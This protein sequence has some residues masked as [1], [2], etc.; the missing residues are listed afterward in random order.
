[1]LSELKRRLLRWGGDQSMPPAPMASLPPNELELAARRYDDGRALFDLLRRKW[2][3]VPGGLM[4]RVETDALLGLSARELRDYWTGVW[5]EA[6]LGP[7]HAVR[8]WY[9]GL[10]ADIFRGKRVLEIG[11]GMGIDGLHFIKAGARWHF[12]D[13]VQSNLDL[14]AR[15]LDAFG[16]T[17][18]GFTWLRDLASIDALP[19][20]FDFIYAQGSL[21]NLPFALAR[22]ETL[23]LVRHLRPGGR[24]IELCYPKERWEREGALPFAAWGAKTDGERTPW[25]EWYDLARLR[26]RFDPVGVRDL[27]A[28]NFHHDDFNW[29]DLVIDD[30]PSAGAVSAALAQPAGQAVPHWPEIGQYAGSVSLSG[31]IWRHRELLAGDAD[32]AR[33]LAAVPRP[34]FVRVVDPLDLDTEMG[35]QADGWLD[36][37]DRAR[38]YTERSMEADDAVILAHVYRA[39]APRRHLE[40]GTWEGFGASLCARNCAAEIWTINL[41]AGEP[42]ADGGPAYSTVRDAGEVARIG[43]ITPLELDEQGRPIYQTDAGEFIGWRYRAEG[44]GARVHQILADST[45][46]DSSAFTDGFF[47]TILIDGGHQ[48]EVVHADTEQALRLLRP[49][50]LMIWHDFCPS[51]LVMNYAG[52][53]RGVVSALH[54]HWAEWSPRFDQLFWIRDSYILIGRLAS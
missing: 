39:A 14:I 35:W 33:A 6:S 8:G 17:C 3:E 21:I 40:F 36:G 29:F 42:R 34:V 37:F 19:D 23:R 15:E 44:F 26:Q 2:N 41:P 24:W 4:D 5:S 45:S 49:G 16:L 7:A 18:D 31:L 27:L 25:M 1:M 22:E 32:G 30:I 51:D 28:F 46:W 52:A 13:I 10:Y 48:M 20:G 9:H 11:S 50:G 12:A 47:D 53:T 43:A 54:A 38:P